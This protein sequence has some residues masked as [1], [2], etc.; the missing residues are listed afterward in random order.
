GAGAGDDRERRRPA[1]DPQ[2][3]PPGTRERLRPP[4][5]DWLFA[6][7]YCPRNL[8]D[9]LL[10]GPVRSFCQF[11]LGSGL[12]ERWFFV[13]YSDPEP[14]LRLRF[15]GSPERLI[16]DLFAKVC[17]W[18]GELIADGSCRRIAFD[19][20]E[21]EIERYGGV[22]GVEAA[23]ALFAADSAAVVELL[24]LTAELATIDRTAL[25][26][27]SV[28]ALLEARGLAPAQRLE[29]Y[30]GEVASR[31]H[32]GDDY[33]ARQSALRRLLGDPAGLAGEPAGTALERILAARG[34]AIVPIGARLRELADGGELESSLER[35]CQS[36]VHLHC[37]RLLGAGP[38]TE[39]HVLGLLLRT[40]ES[41]DRAPV[42][43]R[44]ASA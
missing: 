43:A 35:L 27:L 2:R 23:E 38:P 3:Q 19:T 22:R 8:E 9:D 30:R 37:N 39:Q 44:E 6:K 17:A 4:G 31:H 15:A 21:R 24:R 40:R 7:L 25:A 5:S 1:T 36:Y 14:H 10:A 28:D 34:A 42:V 41:L 29:W 32:S 18:T 26:V 11:A 20:Y 33:R 16:G 12:A 13:R